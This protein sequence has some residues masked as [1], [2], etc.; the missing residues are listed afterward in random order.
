MEIYCGNNALDS[1][2]VNGTKII[3]NKLKCFRKGVGQGLKMPYDKKYTE[4]YQ[5]INNTVIYCG[6][7]ENLPEN[8][9]YT[10]MGDNVRCLQKGIAVGKRIKAGR[11]YKGVI[12]E[13]FYLFLIFTILDI[14]IY[15]TIYMLKPSFL[16]RDRDS[17]EKEIDDDKFLFFFIITSYV[18][19]R[20]IFY[21]FKNNFGL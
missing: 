10:E 13:Y 3:G 7:A 5:P 18:L 16:L 2:I 15:R 6:T 1:G 19:F 9:G 21:I 12:I 11:G 8:A 17:N 4:R 20:I 14:G